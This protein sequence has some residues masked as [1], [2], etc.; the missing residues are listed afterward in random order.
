MKLSLSD[1]NDAPRLREEQAV[2]F[3]GL[4]LCN[5]GGGCLTTPTAE[6]MVMRREPSL[7]ERS[8]Y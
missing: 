3:K 1:A 7:A 8:Q 4:E 5:D 6:S 2:S